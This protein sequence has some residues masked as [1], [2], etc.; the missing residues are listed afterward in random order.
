[1]IYLPKSRFQLSHEMPVY[2]GGTVAAEGQC[3][4]SKSGTGGNGVEPSASSNANQTF[5]GFSVSDMITLASFPKVDSFVVTGGASTTVTLSRTP[6]A[7]SY[8][9]FADGVELTE[10]TDYTLSGATITWVNSQAGKTV[11]VNY[12]FAPT[13]VE[14]QSIQGDIRP[15]GAPGALLG[16]VG[17]AK[18]GVIYTSQYDTAV[19]YT[20]ANPAL[21][22]GAN[23]RVTI[24][25][26]GL[27]I[28]GWVI[29]APNANG[30]DGAFLGIA[31][32]AD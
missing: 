32:N 8:I 13:V 2:T 15:G 25:G 21:K 31:F 24:G 14:A 27:A 22:T 20:A 11:Q 4:V 23:G 10:T 9:V 5:V 7:S 29:Q 18:S 3:L 6:Q 1:M 12:R 26:S 17:V 16:Q 28:R 19:N 30:P